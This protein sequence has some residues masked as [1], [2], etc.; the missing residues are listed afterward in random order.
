ML[1][2]SSEVSVEVD[3]VDIRRQNVLGKGKK[4]SKGSMADMLESE[5]QRR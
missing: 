1:E 3:H 2:Q 4:Q 5:E